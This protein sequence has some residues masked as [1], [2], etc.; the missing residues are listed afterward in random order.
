M[1]VTPNT[2]PQ[3]SK[4]KNTMLIIFDI[5]NFMHIHRRKKIICE[6]GTLLFK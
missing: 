3:K 2:T 1:R 6:E 5:F 4:L